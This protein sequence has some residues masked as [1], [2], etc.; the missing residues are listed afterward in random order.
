MVHEEKKNTF[1]DKR[2]LI[3]GLARSGIGAANLLVSLGA[4]VYVTDMKPYDALEDNIKKL[5]PSIEIIA[6]AHPPEIFEASDLIIV[7]PG[8][9]LDTPPLNKARDKGI[10]II[11]ELELAYQAIRSII[12]NRDSAA[13][14]VVCQGVEPVTPRFIGVTGTNGKSTT[15][16]LIDLMLRKSGFRTITGGNIGNALTDELNNAR[17][18][19]QELRVD[20]VV[21]E[22]SSFQL[23]S[24]QSFKPSLS[25]IL[26]ITADHLDRYNSMEEYIDAKANIFKNQGTDEYLILNADDP[27]VM[28]LY[29][30]RFR[31]K[32]SHVREINTFFFSRT[33]EVEGI[34]LKKGGL[35]L[36]LLSTPGTALSESLQKGPVP[37]FSLISIDEIKMRGIHNIENAMASS[38]AAFISGCSPD[39]ISDVLKDFPGLEHRLEYIGE[40]N[41]IRFINDSKGTNIGAVM[42][43]LESFENIVLIMGGRDKDGDF[44]RLKNL[45]RQKVKALILMGEAKEKIAKAVGGAAHIIFVNDLHEAVHMSLSRAS[46]GDVVLLSPGCTSFDMFSDFEERGRRFKEA[47]KEV[48]DSKSGMHEESGEL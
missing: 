37:P 41:N 20:Y 45:L 15:T 40:I 7:S 32:D 18:N 31:Q 26:N 5:S 3:V 34:Y 16:T 28:K 10:P 21:A 4:K 24:I 25:L 2:V 35:F 27:E 48:Q 6:G 8:V 1:Q 12:H 38:L 29:Q 36:N 19:N 17:C 44:T 42:K 22:I 9:P 39:A 13:G 11:G 14:G 47:V 23:E 43:S 46:A 33:G 30:S